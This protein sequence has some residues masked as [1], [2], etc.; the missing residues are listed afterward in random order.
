MNSVVR[1]K[2]PSGAEAV[3][4][5]GFSWPAFLFGP[6]WAIAKRQWALFWLMAAAFIAVNGIASVA[7][8]SQNIAL[9]LLSLALLIGYMVVCGLYANRWHRY[10]LERQGYRR[11]V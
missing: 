3:V 11:D 6:F 2:H 8:H 10:F 4:G 9:L 7:Q 5:T 1:L